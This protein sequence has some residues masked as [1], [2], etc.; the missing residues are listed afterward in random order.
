MTPNMFNVNLWKTSGHYGKYN[1][2]MF[3]VKISNA[4]AS[5]TVEEMHGL[6]PMNCPAHCL[7]FDN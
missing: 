5:G 7:M 2:N 4:E 1:A 6:K 3:Y